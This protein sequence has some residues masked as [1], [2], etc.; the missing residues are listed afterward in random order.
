VAS[1][2]EAK[3]SGKGGEKKRREKGR[4]FYPF[5][6]MTERGGKA[7]HKK[8]GKKQG[9]AW[10]GTKEPKGSFLL[11]RGKSERFHYSIRDRGGGGKERSSEKRSQK[12]ESRVLGKLEG[13]GIILQVFSRKWSRRLTG[14]LRGGRRHQVP[15]R[16]H[17]GSVEEEIGTRGHFRKEDGEGTWSESKIGHGARNLLERS[18][19]GEK[20]AFA[21]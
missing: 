11:G 21:F 14:I 15:L 10:G 20:G 6:C 13:E 4:P 9:T 19:L 1:P 16:V 3:S 12:E 5:L 18:P 7:S 17:R 8:S 2:G